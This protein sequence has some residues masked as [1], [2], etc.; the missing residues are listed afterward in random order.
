MEKMRLNRYIAMSGVCS[1]RNADKLIEEGKVNINGKCIKELG[2]LVMQG[3]KVEVSGKLL[4]QVE[5]V[6][7][8]INKPLGYVTTTSEQFN[9]PCVMDIIKEPGRLYPVG[10]LDMYSQGLLLIT[11]DGDFAKKITHPT[12]HVS[13][14]Y[15]VLLDREITK[16]D[17]DKL[18]NGVD[19][20]EYITAPAKVTPN[21]N[22][23]I[24][25]ISEGK[26]RQI[27]KM[28]QA[29]GYN[30]QNLIRTKIGNLTLM[31]LA[32]GKYIK[33]NNEDLSKIF[34]K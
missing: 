24:I 29:V 15:E 25:T 18:S 26:N 20:G 8:M 5:K 21:K 3:D 33:L 9:R 30:V 22:K 23:I 27:R 12:E 31:G 10:R 34:N 1:R 4:D 32:S 6:Y 19:I 7:I 28:C 13:K 17:I 16:E 2:T 11:N 14:T